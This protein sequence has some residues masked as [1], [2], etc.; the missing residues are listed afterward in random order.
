MK[1][2]NPETWQIPP[3]WHQN[4]EPEI[5]QELQALREFAQAALKISS[6]M[7]AQLDPFEPGY[8]K[9][10]L[11]HKQVHL[12]EVYT[13][14]EATGLV[15]TLYAPIEDAREEEFHFRTVD[16][17]VDILKKAVSRT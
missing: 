11:F 4:Y 7:S 13:N 9:V 6:D 1:N 5:S 17:G 16:E 3:E 2:A 10:D 15:Y 14:I 12:A 8:L